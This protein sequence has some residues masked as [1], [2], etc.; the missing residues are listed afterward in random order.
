[1]RVGRQRYDGLYL[2]RSGQ[3]A[4]SMPAPSGSSP[5]FATFF[6]VDRWC[7]HVERALQFTLRR[8]VAEST[9]ARR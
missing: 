2:K 8:T 9:R 3:L 7:W 5:R 6:A 1:M 4:I